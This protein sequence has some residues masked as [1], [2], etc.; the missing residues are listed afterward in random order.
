MNPQIEDEKLKVS[1]IIPVYNAEKYLARCLAAVLGQTHKDLEIILINDGSTDASGDIIRSFGDERIVVIEKENGGV[2]AARN[3]G[4]QRVTGSRVVFVDADDYPE[5]DYIEKMAGA[6]D[7]RGCGLVVCGYRYRDI[8]DRETGGFPN[9]REA[10][11]LSGD[12]YLSGEE[13]TAGIM[14]HESIASCLWNKMF[15]AELL[16]GMTFDESIAIGEDLLFLVEYIMKC[17]AFYLVADPLY[18][19]LINPGGAMKTIMEKTEF[20]SKWLSEWESICRAEE[21]YPAPSR[22]IRDVFEYKKMLIANKILTKAAK[23]GFK[24]PECGEMREYV[25]KHRI[26][27]VRNPYLKAGVKVKAFSY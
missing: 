6:M 23:C 1:V 2:S 25:R 13:V 9:K 26:R 18:N 16:S 22:M 3:D 21:Y 20:E 4:L 12:G 11:H 7:R 27:A 15:K 24:G 14:L 8:Q 17:D 5:P 10:L 19:Y